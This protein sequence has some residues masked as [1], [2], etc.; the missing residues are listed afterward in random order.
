MIQNNREAIVGM[1]LALV[2]ILYVLL[3]YPAV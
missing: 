2:L 1:T 3:A